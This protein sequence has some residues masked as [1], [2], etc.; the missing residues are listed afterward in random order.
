MWL[1]GFSTT[2]P[3]MMWIIAAVVVVLVVAIILRKFALTSNYGKGDKSDIRSYTLEELRGAT[4][5]FGVQIG[6]GA[7]CRV[8]LAELG[9]GKFGA[10]KRIMNE[11]GGSRRV[12][13]DEISLLLKVS[14]PNLV[15]L[16]GFC[17]DRE[18]QLLVL[19]YVP[20]RSL[21]ERMHTSEGQKAGI[22]SWESR[23]SIGLDI[24]K[25]LH[26]LHSQAHQ[27]IIHRD[28]KSSNILLLDDNHA[29]L[30]DFGLSKLH[31]PLK[32]TTIKGSFGYIDTTYLNTGLVSPKS[33]VYSFGVVVLELITGLKS[34]QGP[35]TLAEWT[36]PW[37]MNHR[38]DIDLMAAMLLD[39]KLHGK[40]HFGQLRVL[41]ELTN[42][43]LND[44]WEARPDMGQ[45]VDTLCTC[46]QMQPSTC[47][48]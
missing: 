34:S 8:Y 39:P 21:F 18:E 5:D 25:A 45:I 32:P 36:H 9:D 16:L 17:L 4:R 24:A 46:V 20:K 6:V 1:L 26:Y 23:L 15:S 11:R 42:W 43:A 33:D 35:T 13:L 38:N 22:L 40:A 37:R 31:G 27:P 14:H 48:N 10:V 29:K 7:T 2:N 41:V 12:F 28:V 44:R 30:A 19:E 47:L 3:K